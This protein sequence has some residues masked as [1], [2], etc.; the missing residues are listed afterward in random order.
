[1]AHNRTNTSVNS[2]KEKIRLASFALGAFVCVC[3]FF[4]YLAQ[5]YFD[6][7]GFYTVFVPFLLLS[8][9][10]TVFG[11]RLAAH[12]AEPVER[13]SLLAKSFERGLTTTLPKT[14]GA[15]ETDEL[16]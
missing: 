15:A 6:T 11:L 14:T 7:P 12:I 1:M 16:L 4:V 8:I 5:P 13:V 9:L 3:G 2:L 10:V